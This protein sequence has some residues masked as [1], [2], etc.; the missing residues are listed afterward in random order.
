MSGRGDPPAGG[1]TRGRGAS[2]WPTGSAHWR[3][4]YPPGQAGQARRV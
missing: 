4:H 2:R 1:V 3:Q